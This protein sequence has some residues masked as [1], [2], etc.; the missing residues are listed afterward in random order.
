MDDRERPFLGKIGQALID[1]GIEY[2]RVDRYDGS[3]VSETCFRR[4]GGFSVETGDEIGEAPECLSKRREYARLRAAFGLRSIVVRADR[5]VRLTVALE[6]GDV[7]VV[8]PAAPSPT[9]LILGGDGVVEFSP[10]EHGDSLVLY[11]GRSD[12]RFETIEVAGRLVAENL[13]LAEM[14]A[15]PAG[16]RHWAAE[17]DGKTAV[18]LGARGFTSGAD[19]DIAPPSPELIEQLRALGY[20]E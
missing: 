10:D 20:I 15:D 18:S 7:L 6:D 5:P 11:P 3:G 16:V 19:D 1:G 8:H 4:P 12:L 9:P 14:V 13:S 17:I 2:R